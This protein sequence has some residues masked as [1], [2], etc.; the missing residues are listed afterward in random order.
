MAQRFF[1]HQCSV[2]IP[3][4]GPDFTCPT[5]QSGFIEELLPE[6]QQ[7]PPVDGED[8]EDDMDFEMAGPLAAL[9]PGFGFDVREAGG[10][11]GGVRAR[12]HLHTQ[13]PLRPMRRRGPTGPDRRVEQFLQDVIFNVGGMGF[14]VNGQPG[15][16]GLQFHFVPGNQGFQI[17]GP[18]G[19]QIHGHPG[20]YAWGRGGLDAI[21]TQML[22]Q[23]DGTGQPP[24]APESIQDIPTVGVSQALLDKN[25]NCSVCWE[26]FKLQEEVKQLE[27][28]HCF[29]TDCIV[30]WLQLHGTCPVCRKVLSG[31]E[32]AARAGGERQEGDHHTGGGGA[33]DLG[34][35]EEGEG[36]A[37]Q[38][39]TGLAGLIQSAFQVLGGGWSA[40]ARGSTS[41]TSTSAAASSSTPAARSFTTSS[42]A[43]TSAS[44]ASSPAGLAAT[45]ISPN[46]AQARAAEE[47]EDGTPSSRRPRLDSAMFDFDLE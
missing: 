23:M 18:S 36:G 40:Q 44:T 5:C 17:S 26:D 8:D 6:A 10:G 45:P 32:G 30:P 39:P 12:Y 34:G 7:M 24:M 13:G 11:G 21:I 19:M 2:E 42:T 16:G 22:N 41:P 47:E 3:R 31:E 14:S 1:C 35:Q 27:C 4:V 25:P 28:Q 29:H 43:T 20:D 38:R 46:S 9:L 15:G 33:A 37:E